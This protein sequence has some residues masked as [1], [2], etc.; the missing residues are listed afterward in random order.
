MAKRNFAYLSLEEIFGGTLPTYTQTFSTASRTVA[1]L[2]SAVL[3]DNGGGT[4]A[5]GTIAEIANVSTGIG[6]ITDVNQVE[7]AVN[8]EV[9]SVLNGTIQLISDAVKELSDQ[10]NKLVADVTADKKV[11]TNLIDD[12]QSFGFVL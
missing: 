8:S 4:A 1:N 5:N 11:I 6:T 2:T 3:T 9:D 7:A 12:L 10:V